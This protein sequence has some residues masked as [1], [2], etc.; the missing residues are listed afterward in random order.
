MPSLIEGNDTNCQDKGGKMG[1][2]INSTDIEK[3]IRI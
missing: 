3:I 2:P 1:H